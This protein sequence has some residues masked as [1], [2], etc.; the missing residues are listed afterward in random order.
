VSS[1]KWEVEVKSEMQEEIGSVLDS[2]SREE[3]YHLY[4]DWYGFFARP[5]QQIPEENYLIWFILAGRGFG[6]TRSGAEWIR[7]RVENEGAKRIALVAPT[8]SDCRDVMIEGDSGILNI[9]PPWNMPNYEPSKRRLTWPNGAIAT[10]YSAEEPDRLNG[11]QHDSAWSD[12]IGVWKYARDTW[13]IL[14]F[15]LRLGDTRQIVTSTPKVQNISL[16]KEILGY[17]G[18][19]LTTG[20]TYENLDNLSENFRNQIINRYEGTRLGEQELNARILEEVPGA[21]WKREIIEK[22]RVTEAPELR[23]IVVAVDPAASASEKSSETGIITA[24]LGTDDHG[25]VLADDT[26]KASPSGWA[27]RAIRSY[28][29]WQADKIIAE[30]NH[31]GDMVIHTIQTV[32]SKV[33]VKKVTA[34]RGKMVRAE[35]ISSYYEQGKVH[36]VG[37]FP[38]LEDQ[39]CSY[40]HD[41][42][43]SPDRMDALVWALTELMATPQPFKWE[44]RPPRGGIEIKP[45]QDTWTVPRI[46]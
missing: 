26:L 9:S 28:E 14:Q 19:V 18:T 31:G 24:G 41:S 7:H 17:K 29:Q 11:P 30:T 36:H 43:D 2:M 23:R 33:A 44:Q 16:I 22:Y 3:V 1:G 12:E 37:K 45:W 38:A 20:T 32:D 25:Y 34:S 39:M 4:Y 15:G 6:K 46:W 42:S 40:T 21:L 13:D 35:P 10:T 8:A 27:H 5:S